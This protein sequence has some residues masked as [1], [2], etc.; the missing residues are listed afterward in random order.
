W[1]SLY[2]PQRGELSA[3][4]LTAAD[5]ER[6]IGE[7]R[8][9]RPI[10]P[11]LEMLDGALETYAQPPA[12][13]A[14]CTFARTT[15]CVSADLERRIVPCQFGGNPDCSNCGCIASASIEA[16]A[17]HRLP[18]GVRVGQ[19]FNASLAAGTALARFRSRN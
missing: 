18:G 6:V 11:K 14:D 4:R 16:I 1:V 19:V 7:L 8:R 9:L 3:E 13:P 12:S 10:A 15:E 2:T 17:R 5:R